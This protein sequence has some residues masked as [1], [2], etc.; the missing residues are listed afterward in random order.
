LTRCLSGMTILLTMNRTLAAGIV[1]LMLCALPL[2]AAE[3]ELKWKKI[4][5][6]TTFYS[7]GAT[8]GDFNHDGKMDVASGP[9]WYE[10]P[11]FKKRHQ[12]WRATASF[13]RPGSG[14]AEETVPGFEG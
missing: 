4:V 7:E 12:I 6:S 5:L 9:Y 10:G 13:K 2:H 3:K 8:F 1:A 14:G 11:D